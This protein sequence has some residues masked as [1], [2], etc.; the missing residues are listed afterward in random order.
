MTRIMVQLSGRS[1]QNCQV[2]RIHRKQ[3]RQKSHL[4]ELAKV[5]VMIDGRS[6]CA[7]AA[8]V[9]KLPTSVL[10]GRDVPE[11]VRIGGA[12]EEVLAAMTRAQAKR[13]EEESA[14]KKE[15]ES[16]VTC[17]DLSPACVT[18]VNEEEKWSP[19]PELEKNADPQQEDTN[20][21]NGVMEI[22][23]GD[24][25][26]GVDGNELRKLQRED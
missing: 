19:R 7:E 5:E 12:T 14:S 4:A 8:V 26:L 15:K 13:R 16:G 18:K 9:K 17:R 22:T 10:L 24:S 1:W 25:N 11:Q 21:S 20:V 23:S 2:G 3:K 6:Y